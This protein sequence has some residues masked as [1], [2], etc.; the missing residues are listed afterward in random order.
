MTTIQQQLEID[1]AQTL[2]DFPA[3]FAGTR[4]NPT[5]PKITPRPR[6]ATASAH[7]PRTVRVALAGCGVVG[8]GLVRLLHESAPAIAAR[9]G[10]RFELTR[11]LVRDPSRDRNLLYST[12]RATR[13]PGTYRLEWDGLDDAHKPAPPGTYRIVVETNQEHGVYAKQAGTIVCGNSPA[14]LTLPATANFEAVS[15][16]YGAKPKPA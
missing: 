1:P 15:V 3:L 12:A 8:G 4:S 5:L 9:F 13:E 6:R 11:V 7:T 10:K 14:N 16:Q 2:R